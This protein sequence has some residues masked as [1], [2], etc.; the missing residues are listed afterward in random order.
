MIPDTPIRAIDLDGTL[1]P[2]SEARTLPGPVYHSRRV[3][4]LELEHIFGTMW[5]AVGRE[6]ELG[7]SGAYFTCSVGGEQIVVVLDTSGTLRAWFNVCRHRGARVV[8]DERGRLARLV[9]PYHAWTYDLDGTLLLAPRMGDDFRTEDFPLLPVRA[10]CFAGFV[11]INLKRTAEPLTE[12]LADLPDLTRYDL[13]SLGCGHRSA[14]H[15]PTGSS[16]AKTT[17]SATTARE[18][19]PNS[20]A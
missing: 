2:L 14:Y 1:H 20:T 13:A 5:L 8:S 6:E 16:C 9:C 10:E 7:E 4:A 17:A 19:T 3:L 15:M 11:F 18:C 12:A